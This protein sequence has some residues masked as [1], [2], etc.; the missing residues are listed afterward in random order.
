MTDALTKR[1]EAYISLENSSKERITSI[2]P[3]SQETLYGKFEIKVFVA[4]KFTTF[5]V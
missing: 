4:K 1:Y 3:V 5:S 2:T